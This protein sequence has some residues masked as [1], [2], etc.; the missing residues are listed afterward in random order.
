MSDH[1]TGRWTLIEDKGKAVRQK[2]EKSDGVSVYGYDEFF[3]LPDPEEF[4][5]LLMASKKEWQL[6]HKPW[7]ETDFVKVPHFSQS[8]FS[9]GV[10]LTSEHSGVLKTKDGRAEISFKV[11]QNVNLPL[12]YKLF[13][14]EKR[15]EE[16]LPKDVHLEMY[17]LN[18]NQE[19]INTFIIRCPVKG[20]YKMAINNGM[21]NFRID[22]DAKGK[23]VN[24]FP[25][26]PAI[27]FGYGAKAKSAGLTKPSNK[28]GVV[29]LDYGDVKKF[30][31]KSELS[32]EFEIFL[33]HHLKS[34]QNLSKYVSQEVNG[35]EITI[36]VTM[37]DSSVSNNPEYAL[38]I[39]AREK[40]SRN[41]FDNVC[42]YLLC[43]DKK[44]WGKNT[45]SRPT[46]VRMFIISRQIQ[47]W[48]QTNWGK[49]VHHI[50]TDTTLIPDQLR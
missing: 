21:C 25:I 14:D 22:C 26:K 31:F 29:I 19:K 7:S 28:S 23:N 6:L 49:N 45:D 34:L 18:N 41:K 38:E 36:T 27:G 40:G 33:K 9:S 1:D 3:F 30:I 24:P 20:I 47:H 46:E 16:Q 13:F 37:P 42:N 50:Q 10:K 35:D 5:Y 17:V 32:L 39:N 48:F 11:S 43:A 15:S 4:V 8:Y 44:E 2:Q 12:T